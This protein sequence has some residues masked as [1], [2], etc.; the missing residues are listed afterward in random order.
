M[1]S[2]AAQVGSRCGKSS[3]GVRRARAGALLSLRLD[4]KRGAIR[5]STRRRILASSGVLETDVRLEAWMERENM[6]WGG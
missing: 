2:T 6:W 4:T 1:W 3:K 5:D